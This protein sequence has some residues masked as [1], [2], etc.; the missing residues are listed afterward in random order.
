MHHLS[1]LSFLSLGL[2]A[3]S[4]SVATAAPTTTETVVHDTTTPVQVALDPQTVLCSAADYSA[5]FLKVL[6]PDLARLTLLDHQNLGAGAP[7]VAAGVCEP[8]RMP[9]DVIDPARPTETV[10][11]HVQAVRRDV[12]D[13]DAQTCTTT[14]IER[15]DVDI[16]GI[17]FRHERQAP[18]GSRPYADCGGTAVPSDPFADLP[19]DAPGT[20]AAPPADVGCDAGGGSAGLLVGLGALVAVRRRR[21]SAA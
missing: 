20:A 8:G 15:V 3:G 7:C 1:R 6:I 11:V 16:R 2:V 5:T 21:S 10:D 4:I 17:T 14:L 18:L 9:E 12:A 13:V 19:A